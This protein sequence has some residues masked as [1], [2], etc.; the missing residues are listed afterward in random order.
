MTNNPLPTLNQ[1]LLRLVSIW[2]VL[3]VSVG[4]LL[5]LVLGYYRFYLSKVDYYFAITQSMA[6]YA[7]E[8]DAEERSQMFTYAITT[9]TLSDAAMDISVLSVSDVEDTN[10][11]TNSQ[12]P[13]HLST[14]LF[15]PS[16]VLTQP[17]YV[18][19]QASVNQ[20]AKV[21]Q[22]TDNVIGYLVNV[23]D[24]QQVRAR[25]LGLL[26]WVLLSLVLMLPLIIYGLYHKL[27]A[28]LKPVS[29]VADMAKSSPQELS[30]QMSLVQRR[31]DKAKL[32]ETQHLWQLLH[33]TLKKNREL[34]N[35]LNDIKQSSTTVVKESSHQLNDFQSL[36]THELKSSLNAILGGQRLLE[37]N[38]LTDEQKDAVA[39]IGRGSTQLNFLVDQMIYLNKIEK[40]Q[41]GVIMGQFKLLELLSDVMHTY[42]D[43]AQKKGLTIHSKIH[44]ANQTMTGDAAKIKQIIIVLMDNA[45]KFT[46]RG[47]VTIDS[48][49]Q[50]FNNSSRWHIK[51]ADTGRGID[52]KSIEH[53]F[54]PFFQENFEQKSFKRKTLS[55]SGK[56]QDG[57][58]K[59][60]TQT[61]AGIGL[62][63]AKQLTTLLEG[64]IK[65][66][67]SSPKGSVFELAVPLYD[68]QNI[69]R[70]E[71]LKN[72]QV[73][74]LSHNRQDN[75]IKTWLDEFGAGMTVC[76]DANDVIEH[77]MARYYHVVLLDASVDMDEA[78]DVAGGIRQLQSEERSTII[79]VFGQSMGSHSQYQ[80]QIQRTDI[81]GMIDETANKEELVTLIENWLKL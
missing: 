76:H 80:R 15:V 70:R 2:S 38:Y 17:I 81:D 5:M 36:M 72:K 34:Q 66:V 6:E 53:L 71:R 77:L 58:T 24:L 52:E 12:Q 21:S 9:S 75:I 74:I 11:L 37:K 45:I 54:E 59:D 20:D 1:K 4:F 14:A 65:L 61:G 25:W 41:I 19:N 33:G 40:G 26:T 63:L 64:E 67:D 39:V 32:Q 29:E 55:Q 30:E 16:L 23:V 47:S 73:L 28:Q 42:Q 10:Q 8:V 62:T 50:H 43:L 18:N 51:I 48:V 68:P 13:N 60:N 69:R 46:D 27:Q 57:L 56:E 7:G 49:L 35:Q 31:M 3:L 79:K 78:N 44:H 22:V